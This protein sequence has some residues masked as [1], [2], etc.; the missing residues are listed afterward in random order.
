MLPCWTLVS[1]GYLHHINSITNNISRVAGLHLIFDNVAQNLTGRH[2]SEEQEN[3]LSTLRKD[4][5]T[6]LEELG[7]VL[8]E[9]SGL[10]KEQLTIAAKTRRAWKKLHW[11]QDAIRDFR[12]RII[13]I[14]TR[15]TAFNSS[16]I[17]QSSQTM[18]EDMATIN[19]HV[20]GLQLDND[21]R[22]RLEV[23]EW[24]TPLNFPA[25]QSALLCRRQEGTGLWL[26]ESPEFKDWVNKPG[27]TLLCRG[28]AGAGDYAGIN[29]NRPSTG[30]A[31]PYERPSGL[32]ILRLQKAAGADPDRLDG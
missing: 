27:E 18:I 20:S 7:H 22:E 17:S 31:S 8:E 4:A 19:E 9:F 32:Y 11:D 16:L 14:T 6:V 2:F 29:R 23:L 13:S 24:I 10:D 3:D 15:L 21:Q 26:F 12:S 25:Q 30:H 5:R 28:I 1:R